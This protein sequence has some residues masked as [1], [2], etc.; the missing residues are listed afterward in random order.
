MPQGQ[1]SKWVDGEGEISG[2]DGQQVHL[3]TADLADP[4]SANNV[5]VGQRVDY[6]I[7]TDDGALVGWN[8]R[9]L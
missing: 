5:A 9:L 2:D 4:N 1:V 3:R 7:K 6:E 8:V